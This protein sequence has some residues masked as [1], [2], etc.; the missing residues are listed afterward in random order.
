[1]KVML[2]RY[3]NIGN[4][5]TRLPESI[6]KVQGVY[7]PLGVAYVASALEKFDHDVRILDSRALNLT[8]EETKKHIERINPEVV[9][10]G[11]PLQKTY[12]SPS[13]SSS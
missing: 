7:P 11:G 9:G 13:I 5:N 10:T 3:H 4:I 1:M 8:A 6:N 12:I 2:I